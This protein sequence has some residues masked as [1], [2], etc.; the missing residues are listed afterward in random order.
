MRTI[1]MP[2][3][4]LAAALLQPYPASAQALSAPGAPYFAAQ[5]SAAAMPSSQLT[6]ATAIK[7]ALER[8]PDLLVASGDVAITEGT[9][10]QAGV[11]PNPE[12]SM[13]TEGLR[14]RERTTTVQLNQAIELGGKRGA[15]IYAAQR[16]RDAAAADLLTKRGEVRA[17]VV[18]AFFEVLT[19][20]ERLQLAKTSRDLSQSVVDAAARR[21]MAGKISP[22][23]ETRSKVAEAG[24]RIEL[25]QAGNELSAA[26]RRLAALW[27]GSP[28]EIDQLVTPDGNPDETFSKYTD[29]QQLL[30][31]LSSAPQIYRARNEVELQH[32]RTEVERTLRIP[33]VILSVGSKRDQEAGRTQTVLGL[34]IPLPLFDRNQGN[35]LSSL[36]RTDQAKDA[37]TATESRLTLA[38][39]DANQRYEA[40]RVE[41]ATLRSE[42]LPGAESAYSATGRG[43]ELGKFSFIDVLDAQR[44]LFQSKSQYLTAL[45]AYHRAIADI[46][47][48]VGPLETRANAAAPSAQ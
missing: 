13:L 10:L 43:F 7:F 24:S 18:N 25:A 15:R 35:L 30:S 47:R 1:Y 36:R 6:L 11:R 27:G 44:T 21:V 19:A 37:L 38:L 40:A 14:K 23:D 29:L 34:S 8:N 28:A 41:L 32:A 16:E 48:I 45:G 3:F 2:L 39:S 46:E 17:D 33:D 26:K 12:L 4:G 42:I 31:R 22:I 5:P 9:I 20:Q